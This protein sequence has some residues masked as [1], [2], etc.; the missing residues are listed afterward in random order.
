MQH[1]PHSSR[2][3]GRR[4]LNPPPLYSRYSSYDLQ[5]GSKKAGPQGRWA[6]AQVA[7]PALHCAC[8]YS[9]GGYRTRCLASPT[10]SMTL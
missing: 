10:G 3:G 9:S 6:R 8:E 4:S 2:G 7:L 1:S 5:K